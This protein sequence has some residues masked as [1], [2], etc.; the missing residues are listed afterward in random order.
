M[1]N[2]VKAGRKPAFSFAFKAFAV[3]DRILRHG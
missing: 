2:A 1:T 3:L